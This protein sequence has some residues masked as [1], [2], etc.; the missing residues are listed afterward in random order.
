V[1]P[2]GRSWPPRT[3]IVVGVGLVGGFVLGLLF[4]VIRGIFRDL[5][6]PPLR[7]GEF[8]A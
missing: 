8:R 5:R 7:L 6:E 2:A 1:P 3:I 4:A